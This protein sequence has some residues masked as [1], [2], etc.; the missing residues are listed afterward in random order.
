MT[1]LTKKIRKKIEKRLSEINKLTGSTSS[2]LV[3]K[4]QIGDYTIIGLD[5]YVGDMIAEVYDRLFPSL[6]DEIN[7]MERM[8]SA[9]LTAAYT[10]QDINEIIEECN[11]IENKEERTRLQNI[12]F[13][14]LN[15][16][17]DFEQRRNM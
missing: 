4:S 3:L 7:A 13:D 9:Q 8:G 14:A 17:M 11:D 12:L 1:K 5:E 10:I 2:V 6:K 16:I 15:K